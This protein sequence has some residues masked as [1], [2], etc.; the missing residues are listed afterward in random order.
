MKTLDEICIEHRTDKGTTCYGNN[1][2][3]FAPHYD[4]LFTPFRDKPIRLLEI[5]VAGAGS[6]RAWLEYFPLATVIGVDIADCGFRAERF[7]YVLGDQSNREFWQQ[8]LVTHG[9]NFDIVIDDGGHHNS[10]VIPTWDSLWSSVNV[11]GY[12]CI[13]NV[14]IGRGT[15]FVDEGWPEHNDW[16]KTK[17]PITYKSAIGGLLFFRELA[18]FKKCAI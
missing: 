4:W 6:I 14:P 10:Q 15:G 2:C 16:L 13:E 12:Y 3:C 5:G 11:G 8:F 7:T 17:L 18:V 9:G 1:G